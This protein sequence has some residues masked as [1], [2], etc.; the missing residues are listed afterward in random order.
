MSAELK[1]TS[2][3]RAWVSA[4]RLRTLPLSFSCIL[5]G[6]GIAYYE[7]MMDC[8]GGKWSWTVFSLTLITTLF[9]QILSNL[10]NDYGDAKKGTD[11]ENRIGPE[12]AV[13]S[14]IISLSEMKKGVILL[15]L[16]SFFSGIFLLFEAFNYQLNWIFLSFIFLGLAAIA[17][18]IK[19]T[20]GKGAY[21]YAGLGDLFVIVFFGIVGVSGTTYLQLH[22]LNEM[23]MLPSLTIG[24][25][26]AA[27][28]NL[29]NMRDRV[30]DQE[31]NKVTLAVKLGFI[32]S[33]IYHVFLFAA[34]YTTLLI[35]LI[36][37]ERWIVLYWMTPLIIIHLLHIFKV[38]RI[39]DEAAF[40]PHLKI[41]ALSTFL[42]A[43]IFFILSVN[44]L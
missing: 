41:V 23:W 42:L 27:V 37:Q 15:S 21:G 12:R 34:A 1:N 16:L 29:N 20:V 7:N 35:Y 40:D 6:S 4:M 44:Q 33:K 5:M 22:Y 2:K 8:V 11:N 32:R 14:G 25:L 36:S 17:A 38:I 19:Y 13:Q 10:A 9:L 39:K 24:F 43:L 26:A 30:N 31:M 18:A 28:L 3:T